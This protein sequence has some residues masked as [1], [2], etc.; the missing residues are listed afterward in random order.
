MK[1]VDQDIKT[2]QT[3]APESITMHAG[4]LLATDVSHWR[5]YIVSECDRLTQSRWLL[6][7][8]QY[9]FTYCFTYLLTVA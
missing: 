4:F 6:G 3:D 5:W 9:S 7:A 1:F 8:L 2:R